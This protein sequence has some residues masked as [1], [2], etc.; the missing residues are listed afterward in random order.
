MPNQQEFLEY[1]R[2]QLA[3]RRE[4][5]RRRR[6]EFVVISLT[7]VANL[8]IGIW[9]MVAFKSVGYFAVLGITAF[10]WFMLF[11]ARWCGWNTDA[12]LSKAIAE[13]MFDKLSDKSR[14]TV[15]DHL[16]KK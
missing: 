13:Q 4:W 11:N 14:Q 6:G 7:A 10:L 5:H 12:D 2:E 15:I 9:A 1:E 8:T 3:Q 16:K